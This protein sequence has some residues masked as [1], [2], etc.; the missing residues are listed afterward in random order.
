MAHT[1][2]QVKGVPCEPIQAKPRLG[3][4]V[5]HG[6]PVAFDSR[7]RST[8]YALLCG[9]M[10]SYFGLLGFPGMVSGFTVG[11]SLNLIDIRGCGGANI[12]TPTRNYVEL[13]GY[14]QVHASC[15]TSI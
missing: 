4:T 11:S 3:R 14:E 10:A 13:L 5:K 7:L 15:R 12:G 8:N 1:G 6:K 2:L 9:M